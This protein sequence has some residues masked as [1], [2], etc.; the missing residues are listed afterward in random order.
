MP[1]AAMAWVN[2]LRRRQK[3]KMQNAG[4][5]KE[6]VTSVITPLLVTPV[7]CIARIN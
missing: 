1:F 2:G 5:Y 3:T 7:L 6:D 4:T